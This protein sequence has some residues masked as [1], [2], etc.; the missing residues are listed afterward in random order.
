[1]DPY[2]GTMRPYYKVTPYVKCEKYNINVIKTSENT[3]GVLY[4]KYLWMLYQR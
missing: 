1:M 3:Q 4:L 2:F